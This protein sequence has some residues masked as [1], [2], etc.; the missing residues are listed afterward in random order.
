MQGLPSHCLPDVTAIWVIAS[1]VFLAT[2]A[3]TTS[4]PV[5]LAEGPGGICNF[6][7]TI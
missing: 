5:S 6:R 4:G 2:M 7:T 3:Y 1:V